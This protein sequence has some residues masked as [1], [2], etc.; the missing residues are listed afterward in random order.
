MSTTETFVPDTPPVEPGPKG[1]LAQLGGA[2]RFVLT[3]VFLFVLLSFVRA[4]TDTPQ[5]TASQ[6]VETA[7]RATVPILLAGLAGLWAERAGIINI[8]IEGMMILGTWFG[9][10]AAWQFGGWVGLLF[11]VLGG[12]IGGLVHAIAVVRFNVDHIISG[13]GDQHPRP[14]RDALHER[15]VLPRRGGRRHQPVTRASRRASR[16]STCRSSPGGG[17]RPT[18]SATSKIRA[19][20]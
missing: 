13:V 11:A 20:S 6:T 14:G 9:G 1:V 7:L 3:A 18:G 19:G 12:M 5:L 2:N 16:R 8:G 4:I 15:T 17:A 10:W